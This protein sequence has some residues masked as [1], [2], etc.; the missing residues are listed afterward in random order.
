MRTEIAIGKYESISKDAKVAFEFDKSLL[1]VCDST[2][3]ETSADV[4]EN[5]I[6]QLL[7]FLP[8]S[9]ATVH[10]F[11]NMPTHNFANIKNLI[12]STEKKIGEQFFAP[13]DIIRFL[14]KVYEEISKRFSLFAQKG[15]K[16]I[17]AYNMGLKNPLEYR[18]IVISGLASLVLHK[19]DIFFTL[20]NIF[21][22]GSNAGIF[23]VLH[24]DMNITKKIG[25]SEDNLKK[26]YTFMGEV[27]KR[28][29]G[30]NFLATPI[31]FNNLPE[32]QKYIFQ[33]GYLPKFEANFSKS[34]VSNILGKI[35]VLHKASPL[36]DFIKIKIGMSDAK[37][38]FFALGDATSTFHT[39]ISGATRSGKTTFIQNL[40]VNICEKYSSKDI[41][42]LLLDFGGSTFHPYKS[43]AHV[44]YVFSD[45]TKN[46]LII[47]TFDYIKNELDRRRELYKKCGKKH[48]I[49]ID[50][51]VNYEKYSGE[52]LT[53]LIVIIDEYGTLMEESRDR[54]VKAKS[55]DVLNAIAREGAKYG[56]Y[57][58]LINQSFANCGIPV[59]VRTNAG[60]RVALKANTERDSYATL[61]TSNNKAYELRNYQAVLNNDAGRIHAN[62]IVDLDEINEDELHKRQRELKKIYPKK[63]LSDIEHFLNQQTEPNQEVHNQNDTSKPPF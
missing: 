34:L 29:Q 55:E 51:M 46:N 35:D 39:I 18:F 37:E 44:P 6:L 33:F 57:I 3:F 52:K 23:L 36:Q 24:H 9:S 26:F 10:L 63:D 13:N 2:S 14:E 22:N 12:A 31:P 41:N 15:V 45:P 5:C 60:M 28:F 56:I 53:R 58:V 27:S 8:A 16:S 21:E 20:R 59:D 50:K 47:K 32:Y 1:A 38:A 11:E 48:D 17:E 42:L 7:D 4:L 40:L 49:T 19:S 25:F 30:F 54:T 62:I 43:I 61:D